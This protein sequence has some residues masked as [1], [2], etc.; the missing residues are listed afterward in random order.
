E[1][2]FV[3]VPSQDIHQRHFSGP[4]P[5]TDRDNIFFP[6]LSFFSRSSGPQRVHEA[7]GDS[8]ESYQAGRP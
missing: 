1:F 7:A 3:P 8:V 5:I 2:A 4:F 6:S